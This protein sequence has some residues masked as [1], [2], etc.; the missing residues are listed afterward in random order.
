MT[1]RVV[2]I[3]LDMGDGDLIR[4][5]ARQGLLP[6]FAALI[7]QGTWVDLE[8]TARV[9]HTSTWPTF[10]T[11]VLPGRHGVYYPYQP[12]PGFQEAQLIQPDQYG[13]STFWKQ[14]D[15]RGRRCIVFDVPET[16]P[17]AGFRG[18]AIFEW[19]TWAWYG[20]RG[21][22]PAGLLPEIR[23][24]FG[25]YPLK[26]EAKRLGARFPDPVA[27]E[28]GLLAGIEHKRATFEWL[29]G[30]GDWDLAITVFG[31]THPAGHYLWPTGVREFG[32]A[33]DERFAAIRR[34]YIAL[35]RA[36]GSIRGALPAGSTLLLLSGDGVTVNHCGWYLVPDV[37]EKLG[38]LAR[39]TRMAAD[40]TTGRRLSL[41]Q[42]KELLP[43]G[44]RR[45]IADHL[46]W[47]LRD[48]IGA[49]LRAADIEWSQTRAFALPT[50]LEGCIRIN[51]KGREPLGIVEPADY[52]DLCRELA[53]SLRE[54]VNPATGEPAA[55]QVWIRNE[56]F[57]GPAQEHLP[58]VVIAWND[59]AP[60]RAL[61]SAR[62]G[63]VERDPP[64]PRT[65]THSGR[66]F[67]VAAGADFPAGRSAAAR[68][69]DVA[70]TVLGLIGVPV[71]DL[72][73]VYM[74]CGGVAT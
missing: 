10:A 20:E 9:L 28:S 14:A 47:W 24:R 22:Q 63:C 59:R 68:L 49:S 37:L 40:G 69:Q 18:R 3:G 15:E 19:G 61:S 67:C 74:R 34:V 6:N 31:E 11:G 48:R 8:S 73:G 50:D 29:L 46:P 5:W 7:E 4:S 30:E 23:R 41:G 32:P 17:E 25:V 56:V 39:P 51:L 64:D 44:A 65:G 16:F 60:F 52:A 58:D 71:Q 38:Y 53:S 33:Q 12:A 13:V 54:L 21:S 55:K 2:V 27:L 43:Q 45:W 57:A 70:P 72:D 66:G 42:L 26:L 1:Q 62:M 35:D 36:L